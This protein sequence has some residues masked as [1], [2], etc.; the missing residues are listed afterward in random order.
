MVLL[1]TNYVTLG[2]LS[3][4]IWFPYLSNTNKYLRHR[5]VVQIMR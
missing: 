2:K 1:L 3:F 4:E 5:A